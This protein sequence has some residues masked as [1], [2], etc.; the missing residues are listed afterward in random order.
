MNPFEDEHDNNPNDERL[1]RALADRGAPLGN[2]KELSPWRLGDPP[3]TD[4]EM[5]EAI[6]YP[7][8]VPKPEMEPVSD[9]IINARLAAFPS[10]P[11]KDVASG[12]DND[13][14][15]ASWV[16]LQAAPA[17]PK[18]ET[19]LDHTTGLNPGEILGT[20]AGITVKGADT[21]VFPEPAPLPSTLKTLDTSYPGSPNDHSPGKRTTSATEPPEHTAEHDSYKEADL[22]YKLFV[23]STSMIQECDGTITSPIP[24]VGDEVGDDNSPLINLPDSPA[25]SSAS[26]STKRNDIHSVWS[27]TQTKGLSAVKPRVKEG[28][29]QAYPPI[30]VFDGNSTEIQASKKPVFLSITTKKDLNHS[31]WSETPVKLSSVEKSAGMTEVN[32]LKTLDG[33]TTP[34]YD[35]EWEDSPS[36]GPVMTQKLLEGPAV[37]DP[38]SATTKTFDIRQASVIVSDP[39][40]AKPAVSALEEQLADNLEEIEL[41]SDLESHVQEVVK[42]PVQKRTTKLSVAAAVKE[43]I[44]E[45]STTVTL[46]ERS[47]G[48]RQPL[49][50]KTPIASHPY[51]QNTV[52]AKFIPL[53]KLE[54]PT[55]ASPMP[56]FTQVKAQAGRNLKRGSARAPAQP[57]SSKSPIDSDENLVDGEYADVSMDMLDYEMGNAGST[58]YPTYHFP[59]T[60]E[61]AKYDTIEAT[62]NVSSAASSFSSALGMAGVG[63]AMWS[64]G[65]L[66]GRGARGTAKVI[67]TTAT[68]GAIKLGYKESLPAHVAQWAEET[69]L[70][71]ARKAE[72]KKPVYKMADV[73]YNKGDPRNYVLNK[74]RSI[75]QDK[76][77]DIDDDLDEDDWAMVNVKDGAEEPLEQAGGQLPTENQDGPRDLYYESI[78]SAVESTAMVTVGVASRVGRNVSRVVR[79]VRAQPHD[80]FEQRKI[81]ENWPKNLAELEVRNKVE[82]RQ[83]IPRHLD[84]DFEKVRDPRYHKPLYKRATVSD[85]DDVQDD[86]EKMVLP[87]SDDELKD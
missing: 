28:K 79:T 9:E 54:T 3:K 44:P 11:K 33:V 34:E 23:M 45:G 72:K 62:K 84:P 78:M 70:N 86:F 59:G 17:V 48:A 68:M 49:A 60:Y 75:M 58:D 69:S 30:P 10:A 85:P 42:K 61:A 66:V 76:S 19:P 40:V 64:V 14:K 26:D 57:K 6:F 16:A 56:T 81:A 87:D 20:G 15:H 21:N 74:D 82:R 1:D 71:E 8:G 80:Y 38:V 27:G 39:T 35:G 83:S 52:N 12:N 7:N 37:A 13:A 25:A 43:N 32:W 29:N 55:G 22:T 73:Q 46:R 36:R 4:Q 18:Q 31:V 47:T 51:S 53:S 50:P 24:D 67:A 77:V 2:V 41:D 5:L 65:T 63:K